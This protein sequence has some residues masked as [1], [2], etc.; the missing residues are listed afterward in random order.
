MTKR[1]SYKNKKTKKK[2]NKSRKRTK[3][4]KNNIQIAKKNMISLEPEV[5]TI[6]NFLNNKECEHIIK[7]AKPHLKR[8]VV[9][10]DKKGF[11]SD[12]RT[13]SN[14]WI[15]HDTDKIT[16]DVAQKISKLVNIPLKNAEAFHVIHYDLKQE[17]K[18][19]YDAYLFDNSPKSIRCLKNGG[20]RLKTVLCYLNDVVKGGSTKFTILKK[21]VKPAKG[22]LLMFSNVYNNSNIRHPS[23]E[24]CGSPVEKGVKYAFNLWFREN[25]VAK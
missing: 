10:G 8:S 24:H 20:Q 4:R 11:I 25:E 1:K 9:S 5:F 17:Y 21:E 12:L 6:D 2:I 23:S 22:K 14:C 7:L 18:N 13:N 3:S 15:A 16:H 19:H